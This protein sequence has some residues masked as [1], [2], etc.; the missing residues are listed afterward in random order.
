MGNGFLI[1]D[2]HQFYWLGLNTSSAETWP[3]FSWVDNTPGPYNSSYEHW[4]R[5]GHGCQLLLALGTDTSRT[6]SGVCPGQHFPSNTL[7]LRQAGH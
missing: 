3:I 6:A 7:I 5:W 1:S 4:G 2:F